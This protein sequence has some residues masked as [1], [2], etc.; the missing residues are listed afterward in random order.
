MILTR[1]AVKL[2]G[3]K[4]LSILVMLGNALCMACFLFLKPD[5]W[6]WM[7][8]LHGLGSFISGPMPIL[9]WAMYAD[10]AD[11]SEWINHRRATGLVF[12]AATFSQKLGSALGAAIPG[13][14]LAY[15][16]FQIPVNN[17]AQA[18]TQETI[19]GIVRMMSIIPAFFLVCGC[20]AMLLYNLNQRFL[21][22]METEL[23]NRKL[24]S[25]TETFA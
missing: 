24:E 15:Y 22:R 8:A 5:Q 12:A 20:V 25:P 7:Y 23:R 18:Q 2:F 4:W 19:D 16:G 10:A 9:L 13:W 1:P 3:N 14:G 6:T 17:V 11:Y 21:E